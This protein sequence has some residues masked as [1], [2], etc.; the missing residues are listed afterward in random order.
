MEMLKREKTRRLNMERKG[1]KY[2][3][4]CKVLKNHVNQQQTENHVGNPFESKRM[5]LLLSELAGLAFALP[6][7]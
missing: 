1:A 4:L 3:L 5:R 6:S 2:S 7:S